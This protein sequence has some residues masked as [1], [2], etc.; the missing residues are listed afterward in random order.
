MKKLYVKKSFR[1]ST[2]SI[3]DN[4]NLILREYMSQGYRLTLRQLYYQFVARG[5]I[6]NL[7]REYKR[8]GSIIN[9]AR[10][11]GLIDW[12]AIED[13]TRNLK[14]LSHWESPSDIITD[15]LDWFRIDKWESQPN[16]VEVWIE[17]EALAGVIVRTCQGWDVPY[18]ACRGYMSQSEM[19]AAADRFDYHQSE[20][21]QAG[22][23]IHLGD[24][25]PSGIDMTDDINKRLNDVFC[26]DVTVHRIALTMDQVEE[27]D[28]PPNPAKLTDSRCVKYMDE[29][30]DESWELDALTPEVI[31]ELISDNIS[32]L[33]NMSVWESS[34]VIEN[35]A[36]EELT[37]MINK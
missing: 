22:H 32:E 17:K 18:M 31:N 1:D 36:I 28:P 21:A 5:L 33:V 16:Y 29:Y 12:D 11:A 24:H 14:S 7:D 34:V 25:D 37:N 23:I 6:A 3:I 20:F 13:R 8:L 9:D 30:G 27:F 35:T 26:S 15:C 10:L 19:K 4:A 2:V